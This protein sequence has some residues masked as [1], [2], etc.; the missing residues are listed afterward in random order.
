MSHG[1]RAR[2]QS[3]SLSRNAQQTTEAGPK[4]P[5]AP[6]CT[7]LLDILRDASPLQLQRCATAY[8]QV[9]SLADHVTIVTMPN[10]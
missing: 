5:G 7:I 1:P 10:R 2:Q 6:R 4:E 3:L 9:L 8:S